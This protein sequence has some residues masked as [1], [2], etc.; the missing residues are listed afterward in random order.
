MIDKKKQV[1]WKI[2][3]TGLLC[4]TAIELYALNLGFNGTLLKGV[5]MFI[6]L[7]I[8]ITIPSEI[9]KRIFNIK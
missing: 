1:D 6:A 3:C 5:L 7:A 2:V 8:G 9:I 4:V